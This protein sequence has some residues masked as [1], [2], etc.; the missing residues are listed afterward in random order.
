MGWEWS[1]VAMVFVVAISLVDYSEGTRELEEVK[2]M[3]IRGQ[4]L[5]QECSSAIWNE[6]IHGKPMKGM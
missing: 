4:V 1:M 6:W 2:V 3:Y 5:C